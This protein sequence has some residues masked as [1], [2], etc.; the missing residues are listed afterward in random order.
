MIRIF[1]KPLIIVE[2][3]LVIHADTEDDALVIIAMVEKEYPGQFKITKHPT[4]IWTAK[5][6]KKLE[7]RIDEHLH[8]PLPQP[9]D[10]L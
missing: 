1:L 3:D 2:R 9:E 7:E 5:D 6:L 4:R 8:Y 10:L